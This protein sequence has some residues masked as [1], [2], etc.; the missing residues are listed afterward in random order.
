ERKGEARR[1]GGDIAA[2]YLA[3]DSQTQQRLPDSPGL[4]PSPGSIREGSPGALQGGSPGESGRGGQ[5]GGLL[6]PHSLPASPEGQ[7]LRTP[8]TLRATDSRTPE[9]TRTPE[10]LR[11]PDLEAVAAGSAAVA[12]PGRAS[13]GLSKP[14]PDSCTPARAP[15]GLSGV[16]VDPS[17]PVWTEETTP[18]RPLAEP[19]EAMA[20]KRP[21]AAE[22][23]AG[24][25]KGPDARSARG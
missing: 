17:S 25:S 5:Y 11:T 21:R 1:K 13:P 9:K 6:L 12:S 23:L 15:P 4:P 16:L 8:R 18:K 24:A 14:L 10:V 2:E 7:N 20:Y 3:P 19:L 22:D